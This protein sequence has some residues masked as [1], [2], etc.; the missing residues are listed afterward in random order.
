VR[1]KVPSSYIGVRAAQINRYVARVCVAITLVGYAL[2]ASDVR[3]AEVAVRERE[4]NSYELTLTNQ[5]PLSERE[6]QALIAN[7]ALSICKGLEPKLGKYRFESNQ[8]LG[9]GVPSRE[10]PPFVFVQD[11]TCDSAPMAQVAKRVPTLKSTEDAQRVRE[12]IKGRSEAYFRLLTA[13]RFDDAYSQLN[14]S[15]LGLNKAKWTRDQRAFQLLAGDPRSIAV[16]TITIYD[17]PAEAPEPGLYVAADFNNAYQN[18]PFQ[19]GYLV[20]Y[21]PEGG[22]FEIT[23]MEI[24]HVTAKQL[25]TIPEAQLPEL[26]RQLRCIAP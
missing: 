16:V 26:K 6:A 2:C 19:C 20:W 4:S 8:A 18:V 24:G 13:N 1:N 21:R 10:V 11:V 25:K 17:N 23:R 15:A 12:D 14:E 9:D 22:N 7:A 5:T 3:A